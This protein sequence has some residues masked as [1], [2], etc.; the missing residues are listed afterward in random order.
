ML[1]LHRCARARSRLLFMR[2][3]A[4]AQAGVAGGAA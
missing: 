1:L 3:A 4:A 2:N